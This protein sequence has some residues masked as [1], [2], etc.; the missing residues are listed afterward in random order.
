MHT[1][2]IDR[3]NT[4]K[5]LIPHTYDKY[6]RHNCHFKTYYIPNRIENTLIIPYT[7]QFIYDR[8]NSYL[9]YKISLVIINIYNQVVI[10]ASCFILLTPQIKKKKKTLI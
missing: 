5:V 8:Y 4:N 6:D 9:N 2:T 1:H 7:T 10:Y 3:Y